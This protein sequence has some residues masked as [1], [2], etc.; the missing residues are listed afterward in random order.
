VDYFVDK[1][2]L[3]HINKENKFGYEGHLAYSFGKLAAE[4][5]TSQSKCVSPHMFRREVGVLNEQFSGQEQQV[6]EKRWMMT[7]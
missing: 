1:A 5:W 2:Y 3:Q 4:L 6:R 7:T